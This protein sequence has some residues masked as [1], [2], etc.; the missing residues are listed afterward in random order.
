MYDVYCYMNLLK[1]KSYSSLK[2]YFK[3][4]DKSVMRVYDK[5]VFYKDFINLAFEP[6]NIVDNIYL[7]NSYNAANY[8][9]LKKYNIKHIINVSHEIK[10]YFV[11][12]NEFN[13]FRMEIFD[14]EKDSIKDFLKPALELLA[15]LK[16]QG[17]NILIHCYMGSSR[18]AI[19][20]MLYLIKYYNMTTKQA[21]TYI[22]DRR[23]IIN[24]NL[25]FLVEL[26]VF[27][28][29]LKKQH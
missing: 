26:E 4:I 25:K 5:D 21:L 28:K 12:E 11:S 29:K 17:G 3:G 8:R 22:K 6:N 18:S 13:Y 23:K 10:N 7:G 15:K 9:L 24:P 14:R 16:K 2:D 1:D 19:I 20:T 27:R